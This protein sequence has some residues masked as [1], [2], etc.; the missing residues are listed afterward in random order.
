MSLKDLLQSEIKINNIKIKVIATHGELIIVG[1]TSM[2]SICCAS[3]SAFKNMI[4]GDCYMIL[5]P[6]K[7]DNNFFVPNEKMKP[8]KIANFSL[9]PKKAEL[10]KLLALIQSNSSVK[11]TSSSKLTAFKDMKL[12]T[13][14]EIKTVTVKIINISRNITGSYGT[15]NIGKIKDVNGEK[16]DINL[17]NKQV[18]NKLKIGDIVELRKL[19]ITEFSKDGE[20]FKRLATTQRST[21]E[22]CNSDIETLFKDVP[23]GDEREEG[24]VI[25]IHDIFPYL[26]C[27]KC[28]RKTQADDNICQCENKENIHVNDFHCQFYIQTTKDDE[29]KVVHTFRRQTDSNLETQEL[30]DIQIVLEDK[31]LN[32]S[33]TF[34]WNIDSDGETLKMVIIK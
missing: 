33:Y 14:S 24:I 18:K 13:N 9:Q 27:S 15:Y 20:T 22:K 7:Q 25:A 12:A 4:E 10:N 31:F 17:Y 1:D 29:I 6:I 11:T 2:L 21:G 8:V 30:G 28:W 16:M 19:K 5:K 32:K 26:S 34:E 23:L 3:N